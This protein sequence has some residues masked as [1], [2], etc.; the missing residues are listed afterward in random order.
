M[1]KILFIISISLIIY[2]CDLTKSTG[3][4]ND[5]IKPDTITKKALCVVVDFSDYSLEEYNGNDENAV[6]N[7]DEVRDILNEMEQHWIWLSNGIEEIKWDIIRIK[8]DQPLKSTSFN[9][10]VDF[11]TTA[12]NKALEN[13]NINDYDYNDDNICDSMWI[14]ASDN[15]NEFDYLIGGASHNGGIE[16]SHNGAKVFVDCQAG[17]SVT[18]RSYGNFNHEVGH[19]FELPD[20]YG[21]Y[22]NIHFLSLMSDSWAKPGNN[23]TSWEKYK[24]G[25]LNPVIINEDKTDI[26]LYPIEKKHNAVIIQTEFEKEYF[27]IEYRKKPSNGYGTGT[28]TEYNGLAIYHINEAS[29][30]YNNMSLPQLMHLETKDNMLKKVPIGNDFIQPKIDFDGVSFSTVPLYSLDTIFEIHNLKWND[31]DNLSFDIKY[32]SKNHNLMNLISNGNFED[33]SDIYPENWIID[34]WANTSSFTWEDQGGINNSKCI[35]ISNSTANDATFEQ[36]ITN[37]IPGKNYR[38]TGMVKVKNIESHQTENGGAC[39]SLNGTWVRSEFVKQTEDWF[40]VVMDFTPETDTVK[41][42][43]RLGFWGDTVTGEAIFDNLALYSIN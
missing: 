43:A 6:I 37:L 19:N 12:V 8:L 24:L 4:K 29:S 5:I 39:L 11:R 42:G 28:N 14:F 15:G 31:N 7:I 34:Q 38:F 35:K 27:M 1:K 21:D 41:L 22:D 9:D 10:W 40:Q 25:W 23:F 30:S 18:T 16:G 36:E 33:G 26:I 17:L 2:N 3:N 32:Y 20:L 13:V